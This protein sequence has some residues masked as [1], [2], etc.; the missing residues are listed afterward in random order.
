MKPGR[1]IVT[2]QLLR[3]VAAWMVVF[4]HYM[5]IFHDFSAD[6]QVGRFFVRKG[7]F[8]VDIF[9]VISGFIM[10]HSLSAKAESGRG[11]FARRLVRIVPAYWVFNALAL[12]LSVI[13]VEAC[14]PFTNWSLPRLVQSLLFIPP[15]RLISGN[16]Y[17]S[18]GWTLNFEMFFYGLLAL[19][20]A[21]SPRWKFGLAAAILVVAPCV[22]PSGWMYSKILGSMRLFEF[23]IGIGI[24]W[25]YV[26]L[27]HLDNVAAIGRMVLALLLFSVSLASLFGLEG[28]PGSILAAGALVAAALCAPMKDTGAFTAS[29]LRLGELS[30]STYL[31]HPLVLCLLFALFGNIFAPGVEPLVLVLISVAVYFASAISYRY[32]EKGAITDHFRRFVN[33][34]F[35]ITGPTRA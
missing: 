7:A 25:G 17:Y 22:W 31:A 15:G 21:W 6:S 2:I 29:S 35:R 20:L 28:Q 24:G 34:A 32:V 19:C 11:F 18:V 27:N 26:R 14:K 8:G 9:F 13:C 10:Y 5:Q 30:Y 33:R 12:L 16:P 3:G 4:H 1:P 23:A